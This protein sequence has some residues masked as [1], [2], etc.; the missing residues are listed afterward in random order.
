MWPKAPN[1][2]VLIVLQINSFNDLYYYNI[3]V[4]NKTIN[5]V[6]LKSCLNVKKEFG[7]PAI[8]F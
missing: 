4:E 1:K 5:S 6:T 3:C 8:K 7:G 2:S